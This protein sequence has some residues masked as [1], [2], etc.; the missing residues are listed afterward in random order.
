MPPS[1]IRQ[2]IAATVVEE[3]GIEVHDLFGLVYPCS[4]PGTERAYCDSLP[5]EG[6]YEV[7]L[8]RPSCLK[9]HS[10]P[11]RCWLAQNPGK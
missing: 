6:T 9:G 5:A 1:S 10:Y 7:S 11:A 3:R 8:V 2:S 4:I